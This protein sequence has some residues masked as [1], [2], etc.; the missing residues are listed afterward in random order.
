MML[1]PCWPSAGPTGGLGFAWPAGICNFIYPVTFFAIARSYRVPASPE[2]LPDFESTLL[3]LREI[4][5]H[6]RRAPEDLHRHL[7]AV[8]FV[9]HR[10]DHAVEVVERT[11][12]HAHH[13]AGLEQHLRL[14]LVT[15]PL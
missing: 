9:V 11:V 2:G 15:P 3:D 6:R 12:G 7:Q 14:R 4:Q 10:L 8:L 13:L 1:T 5:L